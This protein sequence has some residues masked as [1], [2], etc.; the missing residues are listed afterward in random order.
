MASVVPPALAEDDTPSHS[1]IFAAEFTEKSPY[2]DP[3]II[4]KR[5]HLRP[6]TEL[7]EYDVAD[8]AFQLVVPEAYD[9][10]EAY[11][12][13]VFIHPNNDVSLERFFGRTIKGVLDKHKL[14]WVSFADA[15][16]PVMSN[17][18]LGLALDAAHNAQ[19]RYRIDE[20]RVY[21]SGLSGG[22]RMSCMA[23]VYYPDVFTGVIPI[24]GTLY[25]RD[26]KLPEDPALRDLIRPVPK[27]ENSIWPQSLVEPGAKQL[28]EMKKHQRWALL[29]GEKDYNMPQMR[30]HF[31]QGFEKDGF[32]HAHYLEVP[33]MGHVYP[34]AKWFEKAVVLLDKPLAKQDPADLPPADERTQR[35]AQRRL[36][37]ALRALERDRE[38]GVRALERLV[39]ELPNTDAAQQ[40]REKLQALARE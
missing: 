36:E 26:A 35:L 19:Q 14:I 17:I 39:D 29:A 32:E 27:A 34:D 25:F 31:E 3:R 24:V 18:R 5:M 13:L 1:G 16:N 15:G 22:G 2:A 38:R 4:A 20:K 9:G 37:V 6:G 23:G 8:H 30:A 7:P 40:A 33:G 10:T 28:R 21:V 11:G 12:L